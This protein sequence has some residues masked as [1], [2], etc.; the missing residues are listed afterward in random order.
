[1]DNQLNPTNLNQEK[2]N[3]ILEVPVP[4]E[5]KLNARMRKIP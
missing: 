2:L 1:M 3:T 5:Y 4:H